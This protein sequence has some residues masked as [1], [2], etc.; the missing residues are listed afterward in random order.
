MSD[1][2]TFFPNDR[3]ILVYE[4]RRPSL[5]RFDDPDGVPAQPVDVELRIFNGT[6]GLM[7]E[8]DGE[9]VIHSGAAGSPL[10]MTNMDTAN[11]RGALI[12]VGIPGEVA[13]VP[14]NYTLYI[15]TIYGDELRITHDQKLQI[16]EYR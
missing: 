12:Y 4:A 16:S 6:S 8:I 13:D 2:E 10:F 14:G 5:D 9:T 7:V 3:P 1:R 15:T 11:D